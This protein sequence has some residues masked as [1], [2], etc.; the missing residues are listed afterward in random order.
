MSYT[1]LLHVSQCKRPIELQC[2][3]DVLETFKDL[4]L[5]A[6]LGAFVEARVAAQRGAVARLLA[7]VTKRVM[8]CRTALVKAAVAADH[9]IPT[10][11]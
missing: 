6:L 7:P 8:S 2:V 11:L 3:E 10:R 9:G 1:D 5:T 4:S